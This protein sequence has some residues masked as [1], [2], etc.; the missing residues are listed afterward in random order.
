MD[1]E[2]LGLFASSSN[3]GRTLSWIFWFILTMGWKTS[4]CAA[5]AVW[6]NLNI[7]QYCSE[8]SSFKMVRKWCASLPWVHSPPFPNQTCALWP[9]SLQRRAVTTVHRW[10]LI[11]GPLV[12]LRVLLTEKVRQKN[13]DLYLRYST[14][15]Q[16]HNKVCSLWNQA[17]IL[18]CKFCLKR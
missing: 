14:N 2:Y 11:F 16:H 9:I 13:S 18:T 10:K 8:I 3:I 6:R 17:F 7:C 1:T 4:P 12:W 5:M 15:L